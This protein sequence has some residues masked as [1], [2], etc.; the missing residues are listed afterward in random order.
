MHQQPLYKEYPKYLNGVS[1]DIYDRG[2]CLPSGSN[3]TT[4]DLD[5][6]I[7]VIK[8]YYS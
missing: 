4:K 7:N 3:L 2:I 5:K 1:D 6:V 8:S